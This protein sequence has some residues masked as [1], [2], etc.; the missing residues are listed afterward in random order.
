MID[1]GKYIY[2]VIDSGEEREFGPLGIGGRGDTVHSIAF[3]G[4]DIAVM[5]SDSPLKE[6]SISRENMLAHQKVLELMMESYTILP[7]KFGTVAKGNAAREVA[8]RIRHEVLE[9]RYGELCGLLNTM[10]GK[11]ELGLKCL[12][13][14]MESIFAELLE[15]NSDIRILRRKIAR[16]HPVKTRDK[17]VTLGEKVKNALD[18]K[19]E[20]EEAQILKVLKHLFVDSESGTIFGENMVTNTS[21]LVPEEKVDEFD[22]VVNRMSSER[23]GRMKFKYVGPVPPCNFVELTIVLE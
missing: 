20:K 11:I 21:F 19:R 16:G 15:E 7:V 18:R 13:K 9:K 2:C 23:N 1:E 14:N 22:A 17:R 8:E 3:R 10:E 4:R 12:W 5:V 6:Y